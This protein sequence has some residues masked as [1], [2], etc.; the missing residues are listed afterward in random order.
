MLGRSTC[1]QWFRRE[2]MIRA[3]VA[4]LSLLSVVAA[5]HSEPTMYPTETC[6]PTGSSSLLGVTISFPAATCTFSVAQ[7]RAGVQFTYEVSVQQVISDISPRAQDTGSCGAPGESG[8]ILF[9]QITD[10][11]QRYCLCDRGLCAPQQ[12]LTILRPGRYARTFS[13]DGQNWTGPS[14]T[15]NPK[16]GPFPAGDYD[17]SVSAVGTW[18]IQGNDQPFE[19]V[20]TMQITLT[21]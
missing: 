20:G 6:H 17:L 4:A 18:R 16:G 12:P 3:I 11:D 2:A 15:S 19:V 1:Y 7:A 9:E 13:W 10:G 21:P 8:L 14:D 5:C